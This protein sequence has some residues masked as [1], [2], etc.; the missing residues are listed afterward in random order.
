MLHKEEQ[1][2]GESVAEFSVG[3]TNRE[4]G[5]ARTED[6]RVS[7]YSTVSVDYL[8]VDGKVSCGI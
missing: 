4:Y 6:R 1:E 2:R 8:L 5:E 7:E 3:N